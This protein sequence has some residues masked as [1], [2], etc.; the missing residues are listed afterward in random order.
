MAG[1][2][3]MLQAMNPTALTAIIKADRLVDKTEIGLGSAGEVF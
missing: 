1:T 2:Q 3:T